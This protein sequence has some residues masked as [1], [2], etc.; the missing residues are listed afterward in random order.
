[1]EIVFGEEIS[2]ADKKY[3]GLTDPGKHIEHCRTVWQEYPRQEWVHQFIHTLEMV[4][5][6]WYTS[7]E[8][9]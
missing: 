3:T 5:R 8:M 7:K 1:M 4:P 9:Q 2:Y 6:V